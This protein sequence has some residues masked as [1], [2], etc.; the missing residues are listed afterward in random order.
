MCLIPFNQ[1]EW[2]FKSFVLRMCRVHY[3]ARVVAKEV[4]TWGSVPIESF[5]SPQGY[6][7]CLNISYHFSPLRNISPTESYLSLS[8]LSWLQAFAEAQPIALVRQL[9][10]V[11]RV[12]VCDVLFGAQ[13]EGGVLKILWFSWC[14]LCSMFYSLKEWDGSSKFVPWVCL[15]SRF[16]SHE[17][18]YFNNIE[19]SIECK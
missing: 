10:C 4:P 15:C 14:V 19:K 18:S 5:R 6:C 8:S 3:I 16:N 17:E 12:R 2:Y 1:E 7:Y 13:K 11:L 9:L